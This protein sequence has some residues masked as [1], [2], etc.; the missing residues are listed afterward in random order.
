M[1]LL[2]HASRPPSPAARLRLRIG[3]VI[4]EMD[5][6]YHRPLIDGLCRE[7]TR[8]AV[9]IV[10][11]PGHLPGSPEPFEQQFGMAFRM[12]DAHQFDGLVIFGTLMQGHLDEAGMRRFIASFSG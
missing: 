3:V 1:A 11:L 6:E 5:G 10:F 7:A 8:M 2:A 12:V 4:D 9:D